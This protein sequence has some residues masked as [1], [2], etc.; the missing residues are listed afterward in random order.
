MHG[1]LSAWRYAL[2]HKSESRKGKK[3]ENPWAHISVTTSPLLMTP[4]VSPSARIYLSAHSL[5]VQLLLL[6]CASVDVCNMRRC[7][8]F[9]SAS[10]PLFVFW[11]LRA[12]LFFLCLPLQSS[13]LQWPPISI[14]FVLGKLS[15]A[16]P[17]SRPFYR[18]LPSIPS[19][20]FSSS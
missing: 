8:R 17:P 9:R 16:A 3:K 1:W 13:N 10:E 15:E 7:V 20:L 2:T 18:M 5:W 19:S 11:R 12:F 14:T 4:L 6:A